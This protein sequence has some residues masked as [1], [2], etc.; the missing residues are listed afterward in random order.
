MPS[1]SLSSLLVVHKKQSYYGSILTTPTTSNCNNS[2]SSSSSS[3]S[4]QLLLPTL[5]EASSNDDDSTSLPSKSSSSRRLMMVEEFYNENSIIK[6]HSITV[7]PLVI[8][9]FLLLIM[10]TTGISIFTNRHQII[11]NP[12]TSTSDEDSSSRAVSYLASL[13][14]T[15]T[16]LLQHGAS[17]DTANNK[18]SKNY[19]KNSKTI[20]LL[21]HAKSS[22][23][24]STYIDD[25]DRHLSSKGI[26]TA[27]IVGRSLHN[28]MKKK[29]I[30]LPDVILSSP[31]I[32]TKE[33]LHILL[34]EWLRSSGSNSGAA[35]DEIERKTRFNMVW[36]DLSFG[37]YFNELISILGG[38]IEDSRDGRDDNKKLDN[39]DE[40]SSTSSTSSY[41][42][43]SDENDD[44]I[45]T[46][47]LVGHNPAVEI[48]LNN[49]T[50]SS[51]SS[52][53]S[54]SSMHHYHYDFSPGHFYVIR[55]PQLQRWNDLGEYI[56]SSG[57]DRRGVID[58]H[59]PLKMNELNEKE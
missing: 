27:K 34:Q 2:N 20:Y 37:G 10:A 14:M 53:S 6:K 4:T 8:L 16:T 49:L 30:D 24:N 41:H 38:G 33:T 44:T 59:L 17:H 31:S 25:F 54:S 36:Y 1:S 51:S 7:P 43:I 9:M 18:P 52:S 42:A 22:W 47:M 26:K 21:R 46:I 28:L 58:L 57:G 55:F 32:R 3:S 56:I 5:A 12:T 40:K 45:N 15:K 35:M 39:V 50:T 23:I 11:D 48:L 13:M 29:V 19:N